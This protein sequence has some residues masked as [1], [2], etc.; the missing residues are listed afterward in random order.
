M[1]TQNRPNLFIASWGVFGVLALLGQAIVRLGLLALEAFK[2]S[3]MD[4]TKWGV[5][6]VWVVVNAYYEG[7]KAFQL[8]FSPRVVAR[9]MHLAQTPTPM[10]ALFA[11]LYCMS[12]FHATRR[13]K[14][15]AWVILIMVLSF[16]VFLRYVP[17]P[18][19]G[20]I[21]AG[22]VVALIWG[23]VSMI[24][25]YVRA[26]GGRVPEVAMAMPGSEIPN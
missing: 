12:F 26:M 23:A 17:Q 16:I 1:I 14:I 4:L 24:F 5:L 3:D 19:R 2:H 22:V 10:S 8:G 21:D 6:C 7:Y 18:W 11:P 13:G 9:A 25:C 15:V 20:I